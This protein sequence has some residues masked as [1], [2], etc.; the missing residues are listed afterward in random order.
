MS[1][2]FIALERCIL[3]TQT[4]IRRKWK[5]HESNFQGYFLCQ[6]SLLFLLLSSFSQP[7]HGSTSW[8][9]T[10]FCVHFVCTVYAR[11]KVSCITKLSFSL[12]LEIYPIFRCNFLSFTRFLI[13]SFSSLYLHSHSFFYRLFDTEWRFIYEF[14]VCIPFSPFILRNDAKEN[15]TITRFLEMKVKK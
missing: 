6:F 12:Y 9:S 15:E 10:I 7:H 3:S 5:Q 11:R 13:L 8:L 14:W 1:F 4:R 2:C